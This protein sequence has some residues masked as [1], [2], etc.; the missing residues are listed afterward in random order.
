M[1]IF[2]QLRGP[3]EVQK[4]CEWLFVFENH[5]CGDWAECRGGEG[6]AVWDVLLVK[7]ICQVA[8]GHLMAVVER[9]S[10]LVCHVLRESQVRLVCACASSTECDQ[11][12]WTYGRQNRCTYGPCEI[13]LNRTKNK[14]QNT[15][16]SGKSWGNGLS[17]VLALVCD[18]SA[19][20]CI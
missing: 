19:G 18:G 20:P 6:T 13:V 12:E 17:M 15:W 7:L 8:G 10:C 14:S 9:R 11:R 3:A 4:V 5:C 1:G 2:N 16:V